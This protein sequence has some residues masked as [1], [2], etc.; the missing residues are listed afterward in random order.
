MLNVGSYEE[1]SVELVKLMEKTLLMCDLDF[2]LTP[3]W[4]RVPSEKLIRW[5]NGMLDSGIRV[6]IVSNN[7]FEKRVKRYAEDD[8]L[9]QPLPY[10]YLAG[11]PYPGCIDNV[12]RSFGVAPEEVALIGNSNRTDMECARRAKIAGWK[13]KSRLH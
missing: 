13:V 4:K 1:V 3:R 10:M 2:T 9:L 6:V 12:L 11:K 8:R 5:I 7:R